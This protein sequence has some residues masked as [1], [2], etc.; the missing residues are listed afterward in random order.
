L[1][2]LLDSTHHAMWRTIR[3]KSETDEQCSARTGFRER[4]VAALR[5]RD[6]EAARRHMQEHLDAADAAT[7]GTLEEAATA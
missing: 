5:S 3:A 4:L 6:A 1:P 7:F 2:R